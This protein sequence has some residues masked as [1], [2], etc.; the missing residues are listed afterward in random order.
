MAGCVAPA[1]CAQREGGGASAEEAIAKFEVR[2]GYRVTLAVDDLP[3]ARFLEVDD[4]G[5]LYVS[6]PGAGEIVALRDAD[7]NGVY[8]TRATFVSGYPTAHGMQWSHGWLWFTQTRAVHR[9]RDTDGDG[10]ADDVEEVIPESR[11]GAGG[12]N[13]WWRS[14]L[15]T[16]D[17]VYTSVGDSGNIR[18]EADTER[19]KIWRF[20]LDGSGKTLF[21]SGIRNTEKLRLR[22]GTGEVWGCDHGSDNFGGRLGERM[23]RAQPV[24][25]RFPPDELNHYVEGG[26]YGHPFI[27]GPGLPRYESMDRRDVVELAEKTVVPEWGFPAHCATNGFAWVDPAVNK[28]TGA[29]PADHGGDMFVACHGSWNRVDRSGYSVER[30]LFDGGN[31]YGMLTI[32]RTHEPGGE[33][34]RGVH[35][36]PVDCVQAADGTILFSCDFTGRVYRIGHERAGG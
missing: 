31:P 28:A 13:H 36:R 32:V 2:E 23:G 11:L 8:E 29:F 10:V 33:R 6:L 26:F 3:G 18:D 34:F 30:V 22:P 5:T 25:D 20:G 12:G 1:A 17:A 21:C 9:A 4:R 14:I 16:D 15:V 35:A 19:Q 7:G 24:T 27:V